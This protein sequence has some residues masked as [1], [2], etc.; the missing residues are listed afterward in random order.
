MFC[1]GLYDEWD[2]GI[3]IYAIGYGDRLLNDRFFYPIANLCS[4]DGQLDD[5]A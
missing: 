4:G 1:S 3:I 2:S 5:E